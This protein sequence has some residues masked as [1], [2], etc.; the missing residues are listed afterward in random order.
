MNDEYQEELR[1]MRQS[2]QTSNWVQFNDYV[3]ICMNHKQRGKSGYS[4]GDFFRGRPTLLLDQ[5]F[6]HEGNVQVQDWVKEKNKI[7]QVVQA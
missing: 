6:L 3:V 1:I 7:A 5:P 2:I 4:P